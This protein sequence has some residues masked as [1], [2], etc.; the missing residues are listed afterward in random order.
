MRI[1]HSATSG[2]AAAGLYAILA[3]AGPPP[4]LASDAAALPTVTI[5]G[6]TVFQTRVIEPHQ[7]E[8]ERRSE[9]RLVVVPNKS[10][11]G[12]TAL[13][14]GRADLAMISSSLAAELYAL[15]EHR[16]GAPL[17]RLRE[18]EVAR[19]RVAF[20]RHPSNPVASL[21]LAQLRAILLGEISSW[22]ALNGPDLPISVVTV[23]PGGGVPSTVRAQLLDGRAF[24]PAR[25]IQVEAPRHVVKVVGQEPGALGITQ[26]ALISPG[27]APEIATDRPVEQL[28]VLV[29]I[30]EPSPAQWSVIEAMRFAV[31]LS[32][33]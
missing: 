30:G 29:T 22:K 6:S 3:A 7:F 26:L 15:N 27:S 20:A 13:I 10:I 9:H 14:D 12:L 1:H 4:S 21:T 23:Q 28:L 17:E 8:I 19:T 24:S 16:P 31:S 2:L 5:Q 32:G 25:L 33:R 18:H 11:H